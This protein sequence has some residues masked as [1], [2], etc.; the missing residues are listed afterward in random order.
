MNRWPRW[1]SFGLVGSAAA[2]VHFA[3]VV[4]LV[5]SQR[6]EPIVANV[7]GWLVAFIVSFGGHW[8]LTFRSQAAPLL[9]S[10]T[11]FALVSAAGFLVNE[12]AYALLLGT[13]AL[14]YATA[15]AL[16]LLGVA[17]F[18]YQLGRHW[19]FSGRP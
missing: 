17:V 5:S 15:L 10:A 12:T 16:V 6:L 8:R 2:A 9:R 11:R 4:L 19:A 13:T 1:L 3:L 18:T 7:I 14:H